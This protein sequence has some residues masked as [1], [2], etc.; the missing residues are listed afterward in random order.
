MNHKMI[1]TKNFTQKEFEYSDTAKQYNIN[2]KL[3]KEYEHY[4]QETLTFLQGIRDAWGSGIRI[5][6]G[7]RSKELNDKIGGS[8]TSAHLIGYAADI[9]PVNN[10]WDEFL[11]FIK[12]YLKDKVFD[13]C[14]IEKSGSSKWIHI[15]LK[16]LKIQQRKMIF[17]ITK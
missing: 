7:Y 8:K 16:N 2:N 15:G 11:K 4:A 14:I 17:N 6:S 13:Q 12:D 3:P 10:K 1:R 9:Y 5:N